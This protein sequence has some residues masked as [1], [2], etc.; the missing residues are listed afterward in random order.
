MTFQRKGPDVKSSQRKDVY[1]CWI[2]RKP[3]EVETCKTDEH[4]L[5]VHG[6][7]YLLKLWLSRRGVEIRTRRPN[8]LP[9]ASH[10]GARNWHTFLSL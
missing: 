2:C 7:C 5:A 1:F 8:P 3:V 6:D 4:G 10:H 9:A